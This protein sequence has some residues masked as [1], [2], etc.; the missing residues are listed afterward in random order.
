M[1]PRYTLPIYQKLWSDQHRYRTWVD[2][3]LAHC[4]TMEWEHLVPHDTAD[5]IARTIPDVLD[6]ARIA[7]YEAV[8]RHDVL[9]FLAYLEDISGGHGRWLHHGLTSSDLVDTALARVLVQVTDVLINHASELMRE[10][11]EK[12]VLYA[13]TPM[14][15]RSH[16]VHAEPV[17]FGLALA[18]HLAEMGR[19]RKRLQAAKKE[20]A[21]GKLSGPVGTHWNAPVVA[22][23]RAL[24]SLG[25]EPEPAATQVVARDRHAHYVS[26]LAV[27]AGAVERLAT[28]VRHWQ[29]TEVGEAMEPFY[30]DQ[31]GS[32]SMPHKRNPVG[33]ENL[34]GL[35]R[36]VRSAVVPALEDI[37][38]WHE[39][40]ISHSSVERHVLPTSTSV[41]GYMLDRAAKIVKGLE[42]R[43]E[44]MRA[45]LESG[46]G[47]FYS[48]ALML[49]LVRKGLG[50]R[51][52]HSVVEDA[53]RNS[54]V[55]R[56]PFREYVWDEPAI[57]AVLSTG[58]LDAIL[59]LDASLGQA[60]QTVE[61]VL[62]M[63]PH[64]Q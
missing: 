58:E 7:S 6:E 29:R 32:S 50:R 12:A 26:V 34:C 43:P 61:D 17:T 42:V 28:N 49:A 10:L 30:P 55:A 5:A 9:A 2:V 57:R 15:G 33:S 59:D 40:D 44:R 16:G 18:S 20:I 4:R 37:S 14:I 56:R 11:G 1:I 31:K 62:E 3:E 25:L 64:W 46:G 41:L 60:K 63:Y 52:A 35:S 27:M 36:I 22:E 45:N 23:R 8:T 21:V 39:R 51:E 24:A 48:E 19:C 54:A 47:T 38:L 53:V 13:S